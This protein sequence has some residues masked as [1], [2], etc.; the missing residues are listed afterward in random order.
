MVSAA[1]IVS[2]AWSLV[3]SEER[4]ASAFFSA[5]VFTSNS[6]SWIDSMYGDSS[7][8]VGMMLKSVIPASLSSRARHWEAEARI[9][10]LCRAGGPTAA[11]TQNTPLLKS[12]FTTTFGTGSRLMIMS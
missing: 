2:S 9:S 5:S 8:S 10:I 6:G 3:L 1:K 4:Q 7:R 11:V 12:C